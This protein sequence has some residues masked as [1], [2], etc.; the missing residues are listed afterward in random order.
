MPTSNASTRRQGRGAA[1]R[2]RLVQATQQLLSKVD[3]HSITL[4]QVA[5]AT[6]V[7]KSSILWHFGGKEQ[8]LTEAAIGLLNDVD[9]EIRPRG[10]KQDTFEE[11]LESLAAAVAGYFE[12]NPGS[13]GIAV[14][15]LFNTQVPATIRQ[16][17]REQWQQ[18][19]RGIRDYLSTPQH[20]VSAELADALVSLMH[21]CYLHWHLQGRESS[22]KA[23][24]LDAFAALR[25]AQG[26]ADR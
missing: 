23:E 12:H 9:T 26:P 13:R 17:I 3:F 15:L 8:L 5:A 19:A 22:L 18:H 11:R 20:N 25:R 10:G 7:S 1:T 24:F 4:D 21:G 14:Q 16:R 6:P 2:R